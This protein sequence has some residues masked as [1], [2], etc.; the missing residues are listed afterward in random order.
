MPGDDE[1]DEFA[2]NRH[3]SQEP[4]KRPSSAIQRYAVVISID[5]TAYRRHE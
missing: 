3:L 1:V 4:K 5:A 2:G